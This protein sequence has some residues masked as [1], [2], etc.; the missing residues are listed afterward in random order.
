MHDITL[1]DWPRGWL[2]EGQHEHPIP[3]RLGQR[4]RRARAR[5]V[6]QAGQAALGVAAP[7]GD[8][9]RL[10]AAHDCGDPLA[11]HPVGG[12]QHDAL[13]DAAGPMS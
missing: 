3:Q 12:Q 9:R 5:L 13:R 10:G 11:G 1:V 2:G 6:D 8:Y 4:R 7:P